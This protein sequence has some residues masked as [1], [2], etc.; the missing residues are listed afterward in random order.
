MAN[1]ITLGAPAPEDLEP[2]AWLPVM[3]AALRR[4]PA[5][6]RAWLETCTHVQVKRE[7][8]ETVEGKL[9]CVM[10]WEGIS[11]ERLYLMFTDDR[12]EADGL[13]P[14]WC[15]VFDPVKGLVCELEPAEREFVRQMVR[16]ELVEGYVFPRI[17]YTLQPLPPEGVW[18]W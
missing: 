1:G 9:V 16:F 5:A 4:D 6:G 8:R 2:R 13:R 3:S 11:S 10:P 12:K 17:V 7:E 18:F 15:A 14:L